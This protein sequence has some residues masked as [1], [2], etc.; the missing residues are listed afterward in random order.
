MSDKLKT[1][2]PTSDCASTRSRQSVAPLKANNTKNAS[3]V[4]SSMEMLSHDGNIALSLWP[5]PGSTCAHLHRDDE[6]YLRVA[7]VKGG[8]ANEMHVGLEE[9]GLL[10]LGCLSCTEY[11]TAK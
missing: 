8:R 2:V 7:I 1:S 6:P 9:P 4:A 3:L 11:V 5:W 10:V